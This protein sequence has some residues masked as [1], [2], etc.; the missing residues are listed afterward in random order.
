[1][2]KNKK[3]RIT[4]EFAI[5]IV[6]SIL[7]LIAVINIISGLFR[8][9][10]S[11]KQSFDN[12]VSVI[13]DVSDDP[14]GTVKTTALRMDKETAVI[15]FPKNNKPLKFDVSGSEASNWAPGF[16]TL[17]FEKPISDEK[18]KKDEA[19]ICLCRHLEKP[20][21]GKIKC[22]DNYLICENINEVD[23]PEFLP[24]NEG[25]LT[26]FSRTN[27]FIISRGIFNDWRN[28]QFR[29]I[30]VEKYKGISG[31][32]VAVCESKNLE[33]GSC[34]S[35]EYKKQSEGIEGLK[36]LA[37]FI[38]SCKDREF[39][40][41]NKPCSCGAFDLR[42]FIPEGYS[43]EFSKSKNDKLNITLKHGTQ[44]LNS[45]EAD[46]DFCVYKISF[47]GIE[48]SKKI[49]RTTSQID[50]EHNIKNNYIFYY[51][52]YFEEENPQIAFIK[53]DK[54]NICLASHESSEDGYINPLDTI[55]VRYWHDMVYQSTELVG[56]KYSITEE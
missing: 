30:Y 53:Y 19:C 17:S 32:I 21:D 41:D 52:N 56:C 29:T 26:Y 34:V 55:T 9:N 8:L 27:G 18:C 50:L 22:K 1:M 20:T 37:K 25:P 39:V 36:E 38:E 12:L 16:K 14:A 40:E 35:E 7:I 6:L 42:S 5:G 24:D 48:F 47:N 44:E 51:G 15:G 13:N 10:D 4:L 46:I 54:E 3:A 23:F 49:E 33:E 2:S 43:V 28:T 31:N 45:I 11:S